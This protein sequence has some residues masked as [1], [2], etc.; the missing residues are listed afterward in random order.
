MEASRYKPEFLVAY[1]RERYGICC[2]KNISLEIT[3]G[4]Y[5]DF[6]YCFNAALNRLVVMYIY[7]SDEPLFILP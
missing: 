3:Y 7:S 6:Q 1:F 4:N 2:Q 5:L